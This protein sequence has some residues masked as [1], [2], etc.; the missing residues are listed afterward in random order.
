MIAF[1][2]A[3]RK[4]VPM[5]LSVSGTSGSGKTYSSLLLAAGLAGANGRVGFI[6]TENGR[7]SMYADSPGIVSALPNGFE[8]TQLDQPFSPD[9]YIEAIAA[10]EKAGINV[11]VIDSTSH[12]W[13]GIGGCCEIAETKKLKG[14][15]N[16]ALAK[17]EHKRFVNHCLS[18]NMHIVF[19]L[20][21]RE[22]VKIVKGASGQ[23]TFLPIGIQPIA[24][25]NF[26]FEMLLSLQLDEGTHH[27]MPI[28]V[29]EP[30]LGLFPG[31]KLLTREDGERIR[32]WNETGRQMDPHEQL[33]KRSTAAAELGMG[34]Y[35]AFF[36]SLT[37][38]EKKAIVDTIHASNKAIA[39]QADASAA[40]DEAGELKSYATWAEFEIS[41]QAF[42]T[43][44]IVIGGEIYEFDHDAGSYHKSPAANAA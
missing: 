4:A 44:P 37:K 6:D 5:L 19:C 40:S 21:A 3:F 25:K 10:A 28:K 42:G 38:V 26:V 15:P 17:R 20:R 18:S 16:W 24:E 32:K 23:D 11:C 33:R 14:M 1:T 41:G 7:G 13:E 35:T 43:T 12:E 27:A 30:L 8:I 2:K 34:A 31:G 22:K 29:P 9:R 39:Q 36:E